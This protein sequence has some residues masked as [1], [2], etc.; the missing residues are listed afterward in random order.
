MGKSKP[1][2]I[3]TNSDKRTFLAMKT[4]MKV[5]A[6]LKLSFLF[7]FIYRVLKVRSK[8]VD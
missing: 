7:F 1:V 4:K 2:I 6:L 3:M 8:R 5:F